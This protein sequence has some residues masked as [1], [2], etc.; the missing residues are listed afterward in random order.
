MECPA[1]AVLSLHGLSCSNASE[2]GVY[3]NPLQ[4]GGLEL[5]LPAN[6]CR[7]LALPSDRLRVSSYLA[8]TQA[9]VT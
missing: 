8:A 2:V 7:C 1:A 5:A 9:S 6:S 4:G 3:D